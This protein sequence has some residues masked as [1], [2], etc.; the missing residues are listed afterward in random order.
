MGKT[1][2][3]RCRCTLT[4][5]KGLQYVPSNPRQTI[6]WCVSWGG[7]SWGGSYGHGHGAACT[8]TRG[9]MR[10]AS[11]L[12]LQHTNT[13]DHYHQLTSVPQTVML[14]GNKRWIIVGLLIRLICLLKI[15]VYFVSVMIE[16][17]VKE[18]CLFAFI[19]RDRW[20]D[21]C[22]I[23]KLSLCFKGVT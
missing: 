3:V 13:R 9:R 5:S 18:I 23:C 10:G 20:K 7:P 17:N 4:L 12:R 21:Q 11:R 15:M 22:G 19:F 2:C 8:V 1:L 16:T 14:M 6:L